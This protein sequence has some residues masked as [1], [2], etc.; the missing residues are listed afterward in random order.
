M[1]FAGLPV[2]LFKFP[3]SV[4]DA[5]ISSLAGNT[6]HTRCI[7]AALA[8]AI[9]LTHGTHGAPRF[10]HERSVLSH[11]SVKPRSPVKRFAKE[12]PS[13][14]SSFIELMRSGENVSLQFRARL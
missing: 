8:I 5:A 11:V 10:L 2:H 12:L 3:A 14:F 6:M 9:G 4:S 7:G 13:C 1:I